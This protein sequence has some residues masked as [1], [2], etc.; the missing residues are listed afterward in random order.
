MFID[1]YPNIIK[2]I[3]SP[4]QGPPPSQGPPPPTYDQLINNFVPL[5]YTISS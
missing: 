4:T 5:N 2:I 3:I 1:I